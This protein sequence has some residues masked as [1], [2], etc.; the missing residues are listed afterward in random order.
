MV[1]QLYEK[2]GG[3][4]A[5]SNLVRVFYEK[6]QADERLGRFF[7]ETDM[8]NLRARQAMFLTMLLGGAR[9]FTGRDLATAHAGARR[10]GMNDTDF[11]ALSSHFREALEE[12]GVAPDYVAEAVSRLEK[13]RDAVLGR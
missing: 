3:R 6:V 5:I 4:T 2:I 13:T 10:D 9:S 1:D 12:I 8:E 7:K 11:D